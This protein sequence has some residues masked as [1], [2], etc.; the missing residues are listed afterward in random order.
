[1]NRSNKKGAE[2]ESIV[3]K[4]LQALR[5]RHSST[6]EVIEKASIELQNGEIVYPDFH[7]VVSYPHERR[8][9]LIECQN[10][11][12]DSKAILHK[13][14]H[15]RSKQALKSFFF[16][17]PS[18]IAPE[19]ARALEIEGIVHQNLDAFCEFLSGL[20]AVL[21]ETSAIEQPNS[22][23]MHGRPDY[24]MAAFDY[25]GEADK[26]FRRYLDEEFR[27]RRSEFNGVIKR[28]QLYVNRIEQHTALPPR[29]RTKVV[30]PKQEQH[31][32]YLSELLSSGDNHLENILAAGTM[33]ERFLSQ[34]TSGINS[35][36]SASIPNTYRKALEEFLN[37]RDLA[38][39]D[40]KM[41]PLEE[42]ASTLLNLLLRLVNTVEC[43]ESVC[44][45]S[46]E[47]L[48]EDMPRIANYSGAKHI[49]DFDTLRSEIKTALQNP[50]A[51][52]QE[53][54][55]A[56]LGNAIA[57]DLRAHSEM[58]VH[59]IARLQMSIISECYK[60]WY[61]SR[62]ED[63]FYLWS[64]RRTEHAENC[65]WWFSHLLMEW[66]RTSL[67][68]FVHGDMGIL[69]FLEA[70][71]HVLSPRYEDPPCATTGDHSGILQF[72]LDRGDVDNCCQGIEPKDLESS[73]AKVQFLV[74]IANYHLDLALST[75]GSRDASL[76]E[77]WSNVKDWAN[78]L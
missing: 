7:L 68:S 9:Y 23:W 4:M 27:R 76:A 63:R 48:P 41:P 56:S 29:H 10:R 1:M 60:A 55:R 35:T 22:S 32:G 25:K 75:R 30:S 50:L 36:D 15:V 19:L 65:Y 49:C 47:P 34:A 44:G 31:S 70:A 74:R 46:L 45:S 67:F 3:R 2:F 17:Y 13:I 12:Y 52:N 38:A 8:H 66:P 6:V 18:T 5:R 78:Q 43:I 16:L 73:K 61:A 51:S 39:D 77:I 64:W 57:L 11:E 53:R 26:Q 69:S 37:A 59:R 28:L 72:Y 33:C 24:A 58:S 21:K 54:A 20:S 14:Q 42:E 71:F 62:L 40:S